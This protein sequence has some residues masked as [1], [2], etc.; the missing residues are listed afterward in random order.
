[1]P[2]SASQY[3]PIQS[4]GSICVEYSF[5]ARPCDSMNLLRDRG[6]VHLGQR[7]DV[8]VVVAHRAVELGEDLHLVEARTRATQPRDHVRELLAQRGRA[9]GLPVRA[10]EHRQRGV[11]VR[12]AAQ[13][14]DELRE[15]AGQHRARRAQHARV[16]EVVDVF[17]G[18]AE[19][20]QL[21]HRRGGA[22]GG[23]FLAHEVLHGLH[24]VVDA[25][26]DGLDGRRR[27]V[28]R[29]Q[30]QARGQLA[31]RLGQ[32]LAEDLRARNRP[33]TA[34]RRLRCEHAR[35]SGRFPTARRAGN[36]HSCGIGHRRERA[37]KV[38][39]NP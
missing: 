37:R 5:Q 36:P 24:V 15:F 22:A 20:H 14:F 23:E 4:C 2:A 13:L 10:R 32:R 33:G 31:D 9:R 34:A 38:L 26:F 11:L 19:M 3:S 29:L 28:T 18:A 1:M 8:R 7:G 27:V 30:R 12:E 35:G 16:G 21:E 17:G 39:R 25:R 6:P